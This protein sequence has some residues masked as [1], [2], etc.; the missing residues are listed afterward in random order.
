MKELIV[1]TVT[2]TVTVTAQPC[3]AYGPIALCL[4][5]YSPMPMA[6]WDDFMGRSRRVSR[7]PHV[8]GPRKAHRILCCRPTLLVHLTLTNMCHWI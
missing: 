3:C 7:V 6:L 8:S 1:S 2:V 5:Q 4:W